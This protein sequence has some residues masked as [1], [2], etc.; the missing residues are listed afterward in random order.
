MGSI[1]NKNLEKFENLD[2]V[3]IVDP[4]NDLTQ[5]KENFIDYLHLTPRGNK[6]LARSIFQI[7]KK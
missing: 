4:I 7:L 3:K 2:N 5:S 1:L 6:I